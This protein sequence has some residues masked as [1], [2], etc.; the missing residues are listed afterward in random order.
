MFLDGIFVFL[1]FTDDFSFWGRL[2]GT[3]FMD[4]TVYT[5]GVV[6]VVCDVDVNGNPQHYEINVGAEPFITMATFG[7]TE[8]MFGNVY[9]FGLIRRDGGIFEVLQAVHMP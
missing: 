3:V 1:G 7:I 4:P 6:T 2:P 9:P 8:D 5:C